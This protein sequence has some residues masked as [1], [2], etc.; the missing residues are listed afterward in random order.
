MQAIPTKRVHADEKDQY[1]V[2]ETYPTHNAYKMMSWSDRVENTAGET[3]VRKREKVQKLH[4][5]L[6][7][8]PKPHMVRVVECGDDYTI[9][10]YC[11]FGSVRNHFEG[12]FKTYSGL[13]I[14]QIRFIIRE[15][16]SACLQLKEL[17]Y[18]FDGPYDCSHMLVRNEWSLALNLPHNLNTMRP[19]SER[20]PPAMKYAF[21]MCNIAL[22]RC[23]AEC[24][25]E[26][27]DLKDVFIFDMDDDYECHG[28]MRWA[29][30]EDELKGLDNPKTATGPEFYEALPKGLYEPFPILKV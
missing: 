11:E 22:E 23:A 30:A 17:K 13:T 9:R 16:V 28:L 6:M 5:D 8:N 12:K 21:N 19:E 10:E 15:C 18:F 3:F 29:F 14:P 25:K 2:L 1:K 7:E 26:A 24:Q 27:Y 20:K 4:D